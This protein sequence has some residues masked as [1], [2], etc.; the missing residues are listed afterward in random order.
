MRRRLWTSRL[1]LFG[2]AMIL[3]VW[4]AGCSG[5]SLNTTHR[6]LAATRLSGGQMV[7]PVATA[8]IGTASVTVNREPTILGMKGRR[9]VDVRLQTTGLSMTSVTGITLNDG[10]VNTNGPVI[11]NLF[12]QMPGSLY[13]GTLSV[14]MSANDFAQLA[15]GGPLTYDQAI[16]DVLNGNAYLMVLTSA[17]PTGEIRGQVGP[18]AFQ[19]AL[20]GTGTSA[21]GSA[22]VKLNDMQTAIMVQLTHQGLPD[23]ITAMNIRLGS[24][25]VTNGPLLFTLFSNPTGGTLTSPFSVQLSSANFVVQSGSGI[26]SFPDAIDAM[27]QSKTVLTVETASGAIIYGQIVPAP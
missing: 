3:A 15:T 14:R 26:S 2:I 17:H 21:T 11:F 9:T 20:T 1:G 27:L 8:A 18:T 24:G 19:V 6:Q 23:T 16:D 7:P 5:N 4:L 12:T 25:G 22:S 10:K 13:T